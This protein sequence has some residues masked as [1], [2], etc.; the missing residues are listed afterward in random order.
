VTIASQ[1]KAPDHSV[2]PPGGYRGCLELGINP[3][4]VKSRLRRGWS[5]DAALTTPIDRRRNRHATT[6]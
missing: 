6:Q 4:T 3:E 5:F 2:F 1:A